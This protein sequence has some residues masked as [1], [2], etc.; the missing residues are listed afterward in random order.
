MRLGK[1]VIR[2]GIRHLAG[3][4]GRGG[5]THQGVDADVAIKTAAGDDGRIART[6][7]H[8][9]APLVGGRQLIH[10]LRLKK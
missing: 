8:I 4:L 3:G 2:E 5:S 9:K 1:R 7:L 10:D 6:P